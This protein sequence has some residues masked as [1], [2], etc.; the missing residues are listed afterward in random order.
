[1]SRIRIL[2]ADDHAILRAGLRMML[3]AQPDF[4]VVGEAADGAETLTAARTSRPDVVLLDFTMP[5]SRGTETVERLVALQPAPRVLVLTMHDDRAYAEAAIAAGAAGYVVKK[6]AD[7]ELLG[8]IRTVHHGRTVVD[9]TRRPAASG[10]ARAG[11]ITPTGTTVQLSARETEVIR[12]LAEGHTN[13]AVAGRL[14]VS[15]KTVETYR[16]RL[17]A[18]LGLKGRAELFRFAVSTGLLAD[19]AVVTD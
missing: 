7:I 19:D 14:D 17:T 13:R 10:A 9:L 2:I 15:V 16:A 1:M 12:L 8:A 18:K 4:E 11:R 6:A 3:A 5:G